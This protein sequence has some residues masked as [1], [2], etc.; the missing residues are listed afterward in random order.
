MSGPALLAR[1]AGAGLSLWLGGLGTL[2]E[3]EAR[4]VIE[5]EGCAIPTAGVGLKPRRAEAASG[6]ARH[7]GGAG[8]GGAAAGRFRSDAE[9]RRGLDLAPSGGASADDLLRGLLDDW[10]AFGPTSER[11]GWPSDFGKSGGG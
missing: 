10:P 11:R 3:A 5:A 8:A 6:G 2:T 1:P 9:G 4:A 7:G